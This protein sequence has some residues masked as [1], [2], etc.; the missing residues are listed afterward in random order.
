MSETKLP[1]VY[2]PQ[3]VEGKL[4][5]FW[6]E[7][8]F[9]HGHVEKEGPAFS[10]VIP[11][12]NVTGQLHMGHALNNTLQD[13]LVRW[14]RMKGDVTTWVPGM[15]HAGIATQI[16][17]EAH[18]R[19]EEGLTRHDLGREAFLE[20]VWDWKEKYGGQ[21]INQL[22]RLGASCDWQRERFTLDEG[23]SRAVR[24]VFVELYNK[25]L[26]Y[27][28][29]YITNWC[30]QC[31]TALSDIEV[32]HNDVA[33][34]LY[35][36]RYPFAHGQG[37]I[38]V[39]TTRPETM[40]GDTAVAVN[41]DDERYTSLVGQEVILPIIERPIPIIAD[42]FVDP[43]FGTGMVKVTPAHDPNDFDIGQRHDL[44]QVTVIDTH[45]RMT[46]A[47]GPYAGQT[48]VEARRNLVADLEKAGLLI[49]IEDHDHAVGHCYRCGTIVEPLVSKQ[50]FVK[51]KPLAQAAIEAVKDGR[52]TFVPERFAKTYLN[53][54][55]NIRDWCISRQLWWGH[56][57]P[58]WYCDE[59]GEVLV[60]K[61]D[62][63]GCT[64][65]GGSVQQDPDVLD[66]W[67]SS[68]LWPFSTLG[69]PEKTPEL[70]RFYPTSVLVTG[71]D[72]IFFWV[73]RM[74]VMGLEFMGDVPFPHVLIHGLVRDSQGRKMS[75]SLGNGV[76]P[77]E[78][79]D[80]YGA[81]ALRYMLVTGVAPGNDLRYHPEKVEASRNFANKV[82][83]ASRF[84]L[85][86]L[87][88]FEP[89]SL[90]S[91]LTLADRW[92][93]S[94]F[95]WTASEVT[96]HLERFDLGEAARSLY[97]FI[98]SEF[99]DWYIEISKSR[100]YGKEG[101][102][103]RRRAQDVLYYVLSGT[104]KL[105]HPFM[106]YLTE[107]IWQHLP[108]ASTTIMLEAWP[109]P[110][111]LED[112]RAEEEMDLVMEIVR[113]IRNIRSEKGVGPG[114]KIQ[115]ILLVDEGRQR[116]VE[117][118]QSYILNLAGVSN[119]E[120]RPAGS[121]QPPRS[122]AAV[123]GGVEVYI[124]LEELVDL[125]EERQRLH[126][127]L[128]KTKLELEACVKKLGN[129]GFVTKAPAQVVEKEKQKKEALTEKVAILT[130]RLAELADL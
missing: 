117:A 18:L 7:G 45:G 127:E 82:W 129:Q 106:P 80:Q 100:L 41:P 59:C 31:N 25:G 88:D 113:A 83:N 93:L 62:L 15:D 119:L 36:I 40:L 68:A 120:L 73:A 29:H 37:Y 110:T 66:T 101:E 78:V 107:A 22:K 61:E 57:I 11:P 21:I 76:D 69:W 54:M 55:E 30:A 128:T 58:V 90:P 109:Q 44:E 99:C 3:E 118:S 1:S 48:V 4:Y 24:E 75:K 67:F 84:A 122:V 20:R 64:K 72:I 65:C 105:L 126:K 17:V 71:F 38:V 39:A 116:I 95:Q 114:K 130:A 112:A 10:V 34:K 125:G 104:L 60:S 9:F 16:R 42:A 96:R 86:N 27:Q 26:I 92:I 108:A 8:G 19:E 5:R 52:I 77:L 89:S 103:S 111:G 13:I 14:H 124:P 87:S 79:I 91:E 6:E 33:G 98:W 32:E 97:D 2:D 70:D 63:T 49:K 121:Q 94:R 47:A 46:K 123:V 102:D 28:G 35:H 51:M 81:D 43:A 85:M 50:W 23:C 74:I 56:R 53:W 115:A 12:P